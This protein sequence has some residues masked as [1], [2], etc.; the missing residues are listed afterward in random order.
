M[1][2]VTVR[3]YEEL[4]KDNEALEEKIETALKR[5]MLPI[6]FADNSDYGTGLWEVVEALDKDAAKLLAED[7]RAAVV[8]YCD[9]ED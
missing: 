8:K 9:I 5:A 7:E 6:Y 3:T 2:Q 1:N 4:L